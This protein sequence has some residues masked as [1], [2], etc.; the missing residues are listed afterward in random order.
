MPRA[1]CPTDETHDRFVT[2]A[3]VQQDWVVDPDG[4]FVSELAT[5]ET[6][7][8]PDSGNTWTCQT[9]GADAV[10]TDQTC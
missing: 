10:V 7:H 1:T 4:N 9:C 5:G 2:T 6:T 3:H 8:G